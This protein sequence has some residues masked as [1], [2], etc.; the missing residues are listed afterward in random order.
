[1]ATVGRASLIAIEAARPSGDLEAGDQA[2]D[3]PL[4]RAR[5]RL[6]EVVEVEDQVAVGR[7]EA[8]EV[9]EVRIAA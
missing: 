5:Q 1:V 6:V 9:R 4:P 8:A 3:V 2:L 7:G